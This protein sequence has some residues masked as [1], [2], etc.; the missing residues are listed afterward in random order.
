ML[1]T[2]VVDDEVENEL[3]A[4]LMQLVLEDIDITNVSI[5]R[6]DLG[7]VADIIALSGGQAPWWSTQQLTKR[8]VIGGVIR[9][10]RGQYHINLGALKD[11]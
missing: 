4:S 3:H 7:V 11:G 1:V 9:G 5:R 8:V 6:V 10:F 2:G